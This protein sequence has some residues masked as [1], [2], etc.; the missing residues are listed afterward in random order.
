MPPTEVERCMGAL[1]A[2]LMTGDL[3]ATQAF[4]EGLDAETCKAMFSLSLNIDGLAG[5]VAL[6]ILAGLDPES[7]IDFGQRIARGEDVI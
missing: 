3:E 6:A 7:M 1:I 2:L 4:I 5:A